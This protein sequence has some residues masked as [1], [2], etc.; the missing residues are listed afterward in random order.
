[1]ERVEKII[2]EKIGLEGPKEGWIVVIAVVALAAIMIWIC[3]R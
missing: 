1:M 3:T 2:V